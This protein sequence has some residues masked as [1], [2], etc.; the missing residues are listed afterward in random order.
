ML[1]DT[2][3]D[4]SF[5]RS[6]ICADQIVFGTG[7][8]W[9]EGSIYLTSPPSLWKF[10]DRDGDLRIDERQ[11]LVTGFAFNQSCS[12]DLHGA[13]VGPDGRIYF[14][15]GRFGHRI[16][17]PGGPVLREGIGPWLMRCRP[18][19]TDIEFVSGGVGNPV[20]VD[21][22]PNGDAFLQGTYWAKPSFG[23]GLRDAVVHVVDGGEYS[24]RD[25][26]Y[27]D[28][29]RTGPLLPALVPMTATAPSGCMVYRGEAFGQD[30]EGNLFGAYF[31]TGSILRHRLQRAGATYAAQTEPFLTAVQPDVHFTDVL[32][33]AD[34]SLLA[35]DTGGWF[36]RC[37]PTSQI[38][39]PEIAGGIYRV[40]RTRDAGQVQETDPRG[41]QLEWR[42]VTAGELVAR[43][44]D[45][46]FIVRQRAIDTL[47]HQGDQAV[48]AL[49]LL[50]PSS[51]AASNA[52]GATPSTH[53]RLAATWA[54]TRLDVPAARVTTRLAARDPNNDVR[55]TAVAGI[56]LHRDAAAMPLLQDLLLHDPAPGVRREAANAL[57]RIGNVAAV[58]TLLTAARDPANLR[59]APGEAHDDGFLQ[60]AIVLALIRLDDPRATRDG[61]TSDSDAVRRAALLALDQM[62][63]EQLQPDDL[64]DV[65][66][67]DS[68]RLRD[69]CLPILRRHPAWA[70]RFTDLFASW[71]RSPQLAP[72][73]VTI[74]REALRAARDEP[75]LLQ[76]VT[77][78][79]GTPEDLST[80]GLVTLLQA[81]SSSGR[82]QGPAEWQAVMESLVGHANEEVAV[83]AIQA[84]AALHLD[85]SETTLRALVGESDAT[86]ARRIAAVHALASM[87]KAVGEQ[88]FSALLELLR[89]SL[90]M[91]ARLSA[92]D[93]LTLLQLDG[94]RLLQVAPLLR[95][96][97]PVEAPALLKAFASNSDEVIGLAFVEALRASSVPWSLDPLQAALARYPDSVQ[98]AAEPLVKRARDEA[99]Q[100]A[101]RLTR[102]EQSVAAAAA[103]NDSSAER[104]RAL[105]H[106]K[107]NCHL[108]H[109][110]QGEGGQVGP[111]LTGIA[112]LRS[113]RDLLEAIVYP[114]ASFARGFEPVNV[115]LEDGRLIQ[116]LMGREAGDEVILVT[117]EGN[118]PREI[119]VPRAAIDEL[120]VGRI[121]VMP[122]GLERQLSEP[123]F[124]DLMAFLE[125]QRTPGVQTTTPP[126]DRR[127]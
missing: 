39:K 65:L 55:Q 115:T 14:L 104:G 97:G 62:P 108:C 25:R 70:A 21:F 87:K 1:E 30:F 5:D 103:R 40:R 53:Q 49:A 10:T 88:E 2:D 91:P 112:A 31:N 109:R 18:D 85:A 100:R 71:L 89:S 116:G 122:E 59:M 107:A 46:R 52:G 58:P 54:L 16:H 114:S 56:A 77:A 61:L 11:E 26:D 29:V 51:S 60:H 57:G 101:E 96:A 67:A 79:L 38:A 17:A 83:A 64:R 34:G 41:L 110:L 13:C 98:R 106:G 125:T 69:D 81:V 92:L 50:F 27:T 22:L 82:E 36:R 42:Q 111:D 121:S 8:A 76:W 123:E 118:R 15:P 48:D 117:L 28:R 105:F 6:T 99:S 80:Q 24:V 66:T 113:R 93:A 86:P 7:L 120:E 78:Q 72:S 90:P 68:P 102:Y 9:H 127:R 126:L 37:C 63:G 43:L 44:D 124:A 20:E 35:I 32:E 3:G 33:D 119:P 84:I 73:Q 95:D 47:A 4:G 45:R 12:D 19:G 74:L 23:G 94:P 75:E